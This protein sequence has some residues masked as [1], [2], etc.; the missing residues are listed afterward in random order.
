MI[1]TGQWIGW[2]E[3]LQYLWGL[4]RFMPNA[5]I[6]ICIISPDNVSDGGVF[7]EFKH[8]MI[9]DLVRAGLERAGEQGKIMGETKI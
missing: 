2:V 7:A 4:L 5:L 3:V 1:M 8:S 6:S 9:Q